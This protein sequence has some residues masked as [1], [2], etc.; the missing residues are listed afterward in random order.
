MTSNQTPIFPQD[1]RS[2]PSQQDRRSGP[3]Q[4]Y[5]RRGQ[6]QRR[7]RETRELPRQSSAFPRLEDVRSSEEPVMDCIR[8]LITSRTLVDPRSL[9]HGLGH[10]GTR[11][12]EEALVG[13]YQVAR[14]QNARDWIKQIRVDCDVLVSRGWIDDNL[15]STD[16]SRLYQPKKKQASASAG[17]AC[18]G[19]PT[20][21]RLNPDLP[22][23]RANAMDDSPS[24][25]IPGELSSSNVTE[26][27]Y[28]EEARMEEDPLPLDK[29]AEP[30]APA[31]LLTLV[32][33]PVC[34]PSSGARPKSGV[35]LDP[36]A[37]CNPSALSDG[38][39]LDASG[40]RS[41]KRTSYARTPQTTPSPGR[42]VVQPSGDGVFKITL[43]PKSTTQPPRKYRTVTTRVV[44]EPPREDQHAA[45]SVVEKPT[46]E[47]RPGKKCPVSWCPSMDLRVRRHVVCRHFPWTWR[48]LD[49]TPAVVEQ[50]LRSLHWLVRT[51]FGPTMSL[52]EVV[53]WINDTRAIFAG[54]SLLTDHDRVFSEAVRQLGAAPVKTFTLY[55]VNSP[56]VLLFWRC[57]V[58]L[59][60]RCT[61]EQCERFHE[62]DFQEDVAV[63]LVAAEPTVHPVSASPEIS[64]EEADRWLLVDEASGVEDQPLG[65]DQILPEV[66]D[67]HFHLDRTSNWIWSTHRGHSVE[68]LLS[69]S[70][71]DAVSQPPEFRVNVVGGVIICSE[72]RTYPDPEFSMSGPWKVAAGVHPKHYRK[73]TVAKGLALQRLLSHPKVVALGEVGLDRT[74][75][76]DEW[77][78]QE[79]VFVKMLRI[80]RV[81]QPI[82]I[83]LR[84]VAGDRYGLDVTGACLLLMEEICQPQQKV[85][86]HCFM[87]TARLVN[88]W[89]RKFP[90]SYFGVTAAVRNFD[91]RQLEGLRAIPQ[92][93]LLLESD[94]PYFPLGRNR[95]STPAYLGE[96]AADIAFQLDMRPSEV[97]SSTLDNARRLYNL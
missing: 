91:P 15:P 29:P 28:Q 71:S 38:Q 51:A 33:A 64:D 90:N 88:A 5:R 52:K 11:D 17:A 32:P 83:H 58:P 18:L 81:D 13:Q 44:R 27:C 74:I 75:P 9:V 30:S 3:S 47:R 16:G 87:G 73:F 50:M 72:P 65:G 41:R 56:G 24:D 76:V 48:H 34:Q 92:A 54:M 26:T 77:A 82:V 70:F 20:D 31:E 35:V 55:P 57:V 14:Q 80:A 36:S 40:E 25:L 96:T 45:K 23:F 19:V 21:A 39:Q 94:A 46:T 78:P 1:R 10:S 61:E 8:R 79:K 42:R 95:I 43:G 84:E 67:S 85:H 6:S 22:V 49:A 53:D 37:S 66:I 59:L 69:Y 4:Q 86:V 62:S 12:V 97:M 93:R 60:N 7:R 89:L 68:K 63:P 2:G